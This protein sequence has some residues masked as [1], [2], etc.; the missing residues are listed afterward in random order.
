MHINRKKRQWTC[1]F[2]C[3][4][5]SFLFWGNWQEVKE[6]LVDFESI[7]KD[8]K[9]YYFIKLLMSSDYFDFANKPKEFCLS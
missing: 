6:E 1:H 5:E 9:N 8:Y 3:G 4:M 2:S 7:H